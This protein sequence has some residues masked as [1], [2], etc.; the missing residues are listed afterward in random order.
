M[1]TIGM[2]LPTVDNSFFSALAVSAERY[3]YERGYHLIVC[4]SD[5]DASKEKEAY[6]VLREAGVSG[7]LAVSGLSVMPEEL[8]PEFLLRFLRE[9]PAEAALLF[10]GVYANDYFSPFTPYGQELISQA[11]QAAFGRREPGKPFPALIACL[12]NLLEM[13]QEG[14]H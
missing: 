6:G 11:L 7:I 9:F 1:K 3:L 2:I 13:I 5:H 8:I 10:P 14:M 12:N 4:S